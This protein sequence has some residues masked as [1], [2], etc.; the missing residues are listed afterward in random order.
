MR[1]PSE[2]ISDVERL[3]SLKQTFLQRVPEAVIAEMATDERTAL[4][5]LLS[6]DEAAATLARL[7][8]ID[9]SVIDSMQLVGL[10]LLMREVLL[11]RCDE[12][13]RR[14][15]Q[16]MELSAAEDPE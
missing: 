13:I 2:M 12:T 5:E 4:I 15:T 6:T 8:G 1:T 14:I 10:R 9:P 3:R 16:L 7:K 11:H